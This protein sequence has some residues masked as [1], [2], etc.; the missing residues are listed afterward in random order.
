[1]IIFSGQRVPRFSFYDV[2]PG[3]GIFLNKFARMHILFICTGNVSRSA[4]AE[5]I[6]RTMAEQAGRNDITVASASVQNLYGQSYD[7]QMIATA[8][9]YGYHMEGHSQYMT[10]EMLQ[11]A[12]LIFTMEH[13]HYVQVQKEL[14]YAQW[15]KLHQ[16]TKYCYGDPLYSDAEYDFA[17]HQIESCSKIILSRL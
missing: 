17:F 13:Y 6:L 2:M 12:D 11:Q 9:K 1:M 15:Y 16:I 14:P 3:I 10:S 5:C 8:A 4:V 7:P